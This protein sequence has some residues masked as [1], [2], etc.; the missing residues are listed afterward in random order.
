MKDDLK[1]AKVNVDDEPGL[2]QQYAIS[3]IPAL[4]FFCAG[5]EVGEIIGAP[6]KPQLEAAIQQTVNRHEECLSS[7]SPLKK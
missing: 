3:S 5:R 2:A 7:S 1:F 6:P 4:K